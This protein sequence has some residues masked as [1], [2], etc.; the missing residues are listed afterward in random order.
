MSEQETVLEGKPQSEQT[1]YTP[2]LAANS[3]NADW[4]RNI[5]YMIGLCSLALIGCFFIPWVSFLVV[6]PSGYELMQLPERAVKWLWLIPFAGVIGLLTAITRK[7][8][9]PT[10]HI[11]GALPFIALLYFRAEQGKGLFQALEVGAYL[12]LFTGAVLFILPRF[13]KKP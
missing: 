5:H 4:N 12:T 6:R 10:A 7:V 2:I 1:L 11:A 9:A 13:L 8:V 3:P